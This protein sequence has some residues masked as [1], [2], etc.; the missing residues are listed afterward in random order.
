MDSCGCSWAVTCVLWSTNKVRAEP[1][2]D[3][4]CTKWFNKKQN[5]NSKTVDDLT[6][7]LVSTE[8][9]L[10]KKLTY[11]QEKKDNIKRSDWKFRRIVEEFEVRIEKIN[12]DAVKTSSKN[13]KVSRKSLTLS[14]LSRVQALRNVE[15]AQNTSSKVLAGLCQWK[16]FLTFWT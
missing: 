4:A 3:R 10:E 15:I 2:Q 6:I 14:T 11:F 5:Y 16:Y 9:W 13:L 1:S 12:Y 8:T 7:A